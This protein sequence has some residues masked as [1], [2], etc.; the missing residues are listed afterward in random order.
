MSSARVLVVDDNRDMA[1]GIAMLL[2]EAALEPRVA[3]SAERALR[4]LEA[5]EFQLV[6][7]D[8]RMP[9]MGGLDLLKSIRGRWPLTKVVLLT[10]YGTIDSAIEAMKSGACD[11]LSKPIDNDALV[12]VVKRAIAGGVTAGGVAEAAVVGDVAGSTSADDLVPGLTSAL[13]VLLQATGADDAEIFLREPE[14]QD[15]VLAVSSGPDGGALAARIRFATG[16]GYPGIVA[17]TD[18]PLWT[19]GG[20]ADDPRFLRRAVTDAGLRSLVA[21]PLPHGSSAL[22]SLDLL[23]RRVDFPVERVLDLLVRAA[24]PLSNV[25]RAGLAALR[26]SVDAV[27][28]DLGDPAGEALRVVLESMRH[29]AQARSGTLELIDAA[30]GRP[31]RVVSTSPASLVCAH[32]EAG[33]WAECPVACG[34]HGFVADPGRR[35]WPERCRYGLPHRVA[36]PCCLPL[37]AGGRMY[38]IAILDFG[39]QG[40]ERATAQLVP[41]L[42]MAHQLAIRLQA[43]RAGIEVAPPRDGGVAGPKG[44]AVPDLELRCFGSFAVS[45]GGRPIPA[46]AFTR[47]K[48]LVLLKLLALS[49]GAPVNRETLIEHLWPEVEPEQGINRLH[50]VVHDLRSVIEPHRAEREWLFIR[51]RGDLYYLDMN[52]PIDLDLARFR[53]LLAKGQPGG[54]G[55]DAAAIACLEQAVD[56]YR[57]DAFADDHLAEWCEAERRHL[58]ELHVRAL[59]RL[60]RLHAK[61]DNTEKALEYL[62]RALRSSPFRDD[63]LLAQMELLVHLGRPNEALAVFNDYRRLLRDE[64][65]ADPSEA[66]QAFRDRAL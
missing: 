17:A 23:S 64:L 41:L 45:Q 31:D 65:D 18:Q 51:N 9:A 14:G 3:Y 22:G 27:C 47:S 54:P 43:H 26:Q 40:T 8:M 56:L 16:T 30:T 13:D 2:E 44:R 37:V 34:A 61:R 38:G 46:E 20:L 49:A 52:A 66:L 25:V 59:E 5:E 48:A 53:Q 58:S 39:R 42:T 57:G 11:Y 35:Q 19:K 21:V 50:G 32:A 60:A 33:S 62:R 10:A 15:L 1:D 28:G 24:V 63:L 55:N 36:S 7:S 4:L 12:D 6:L 29:V